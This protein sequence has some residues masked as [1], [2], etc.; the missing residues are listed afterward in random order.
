MDG[1]GQSGGMSTQNP[2]ADPN[3]G[4]SDAPVNGQPSA[5]N[6]FADPEFGKAPATP[7]RSIMAAINDTV[8]EGAKAA[9]G[10]ASA[11]ANFVRPGNVAS[12]W[13]D[14][15]I[16]ESGEAAQSDVVKAEK[17]RYRQEMQD[18]DGMGG[19][20]GATLGYVA[21]NPLLAAAQAAGS[22]AIPGGA[23]KGATT[24]ARALGLGAK[25]TTRAG[26]AAGAGV[27]A[28]GAG[29]DAAGTAYELSREGGATDE[30][31]VAAARGA[32]VLPAA[33]GAAGGLVGAERLVAGAGGF[34][35]GLVARAL[36]TGAVEGAQ[37]A[38]E[39]GV[40]QYEGQRAAVPFNPDLDPMKGVAGAAT[41]GGVLGAATGP[42]LRC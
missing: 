17:A 3:F 34:K 12:Q 8:I 21:R 22:F 32:S 14:K 15:N 10:T 9:A 2:F 35:G 25:G 18:A 5:S 7:K 39:E 13:V 33:I 1:A 31:A 27:G 4:R 24:G 42:A 41:M 26:L 6:P 29:G 36:K 38:L 23:I 30:Q 16:V 40:T 11:I 20:V 37:E 28:A 19:E